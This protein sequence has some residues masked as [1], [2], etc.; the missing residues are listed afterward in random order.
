MK[1]SDLNPFP[2]I[3][4]EEEVP[5]NNLKDG[6]KISLSNFCRKKLPHDQLCINHYEECRKYTEDKFH[7]CPHGYSTY[8]FTVN[9]KKHAITGILPLGKNVSAKEK[10]RGKLTP[11]QKVNPDDII[12][13]VKHMKIVH[14][15]VHDQIAR[16]TS[17]NLAALHEIRKYNRNIKLSLER[18]CR[19][20]SPNDPDQAQIAIVK[21][22]KLSELMSSQFEILGLIADEGLVN[23]I[24]KTKSE[25]YRIFDKC[26]RIYR[27]IASEKNIQIYM[28]G[29]SPFTM[30]SDK[31]FPIL[32]TVL[33]ENAIKYAPNNSTIR[34]SIKM[35]DNEKFQVLV[36]NDLVEGI[37]VPKNLFV[38]GE[39]GNQDNEGSGIGL[40]LAQLVAKQHS[41]TINYR[42]EELKSVKKIEFSFIMKAIAF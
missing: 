42:I 17:N 29:D 27:T 28:D 24:P 7:V 3:G 20:Q 21:S 12:E 6:Y 35:L 1:V 13:L 9:S 31:T 2:S 38:K 32:A 18:V 14:E 22:W 33:I 36:V 15:E 23:L 10:E 5:T 11:A 25:I 4:L 34:I 19:A 30:V 26:Q 8:T 16:D 39:R 40:Y 41:T 37:E